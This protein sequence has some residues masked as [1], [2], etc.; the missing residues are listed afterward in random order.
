MDEGKRAPSPEHW[1]QGMRCVLVTGGSRGLG[2]AIARKLV[3]AGYHVIAV[4]RRNGKGVTATSA[5]AESNRRG[6]LDFV[7]FDLGKIDEIPTSSHFENSV[8]CSVSST[9]RRLGSMARLR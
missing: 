8:P 4:A 1:R 5:E 7:P 9:M 3:G 6:A 2:L